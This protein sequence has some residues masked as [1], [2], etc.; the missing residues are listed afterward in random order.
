MSQIS[1][2]ES[3]LD[4][5]DL[6]EL[7]NSVQV[8]ATKSQTTWGVKTFHEWCKRRGL[9]V[10]LETI[11]S[12]ELSPILRRF[13]GEVKTKKGKAFGVSSLTCIRASIHRYLTQPPFNRTINI[14]DDPEF[15][16]ANRMFE[17]KQ[18]L[19]RKTHN[20]KPKHKPVIEEGDMRKLREYF[21]I[22]V[23]CPAVNQQ[24]LWFCLCY[25][26]GRRG[27]E[28]WRSFT[29]DSL[30]VLTDDQDKKYLTLTVT[31]VT[32]NHQDA[33]NDDYDED[34]IYEQPGEGA[35]CPVAAFEKHIKLL[36]VECDAL[37]QQPSTSQKTKKTFVSTP[38]GKNSIAKFMPNLST[39]ANLS[40]RYTN[41][42]V[43]ATTIT[44]LHRGGVPP[45]RI[46]SVTKH[47]D[48]KSLAH[49][50]DAPSAAE[51][52]NDGMILGRAFACGSSSSTSSA[53]NITQVNHVNNEQ[54][55]NVNTN[56]N[57]PF[58]IVVKNGGTI[59]IYSNK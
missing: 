19:Y 27:R 13:Y 31:E 46:V 17:T 20:R 40:K 53:T 2:Q 42:C 10:K 39:V 48:L 21:R 3:A 57:S 14:I 37:F 47:K 11:S 58:H 59:N 23:F 25:Y 44:N 4:E 36:N 49:Y 1:S 28:G 32:K 52:R 9:D 56:S 8:E 5:N 34:R 12:V 33:D 29:K 41:H 16:V 55:L 6:D 22:N 30:E 38:L 45:N 7:Q 26:M 18:K 35:L 43:R 50:L 24:Y 51:K 54:E 15:V